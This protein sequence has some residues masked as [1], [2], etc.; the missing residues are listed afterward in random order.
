MLV[1]WWLVDIKQPTKIRVII[2]T[3]IIII[4]AAAVALK[5]IGMSGF[6]HNILNSLVLNLMCLSF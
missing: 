4:I 3:R 6:L 2:N 5:S 1:V